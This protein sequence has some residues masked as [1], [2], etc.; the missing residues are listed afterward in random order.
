MKFLGLTYEN[1]KIIFFLFLFHIAVIAVSNYLVQFPQLAF[2]IDYTWAMFTFP[3]VILATDL[4]VRVTNAHNAQ[5][6]VAL[7]FIPAIGI[8]IYLSDW[9]IGLASG[10]AY[11]V[12]QFLDISVFKKITENFSAWWIA[13]AVSTLLANII[14]TYIFYSIAFEKGSDEFMAEN[15]VSIAN[16]DLIFKIIISLVVF[17]PLYKLLLDFLVK[18]CK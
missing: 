15:W 1:K 17:L 16:T 9:R 2:G 4:T 8:S 11:F 10:V 18:K 7:A 14:D 3:L 12:S 5:I 13:P 6:I